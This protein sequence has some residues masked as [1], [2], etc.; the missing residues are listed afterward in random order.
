M[1][2]LTEQQTAFLHRFGFDE[3]LFRS[4][5]QD[6][7]EGRRSSDSNAVTEELLAPPPGTIEKTPNT[8]SSAYRELAQLGREVIAKGQLGVVLR[9]KGTVAG[10]AAALGFRPRPPPGRKWGRTGHVRGGLGDGR[11]MIRGRR[12]QQTH[13]TGIQQA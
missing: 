4:W 5:Q 10:A 12:E 1:N 2:E 13:S 6:L 3:D 7:A 11:D 9:G 8:S